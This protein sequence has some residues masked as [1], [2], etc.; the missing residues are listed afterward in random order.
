MKDVELAARL[1]A[2]VIAYKQLQTVGSPLRSLALPGVWAF[3]LPLH[4]EAV[5]QHRVLYESAQALAEA[6]GALEEFYRGHGIHDWHVQVPSADAEVEQLLASRSHSRWEVLPAMGIMLDDL[7]LAPPRLAVERTR[8]QEEL[9]L[10]NTEAFGRAAPSTLHPWH[11]QIHPHIH[12]YLL[13][14]EGRVL[15]GGLAH[16]LGDTTGIYMM[17]TA[18]DARRRGLGAEVLRALLADARD[19]GQR[20]A[21]L[22]ATTLGHPLYRHM[23]FRELEVWNCWM[24]RL[25]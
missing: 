18:T 20:A 11:S 19:R 3:A 7:S 13:R 1:R 15:S 16:D 2:N 14:E 9:M 21:V 10:L 23:G 8:T 4:P 24:R 12:V 22:Q 6:L 5:H 25:R 17:A